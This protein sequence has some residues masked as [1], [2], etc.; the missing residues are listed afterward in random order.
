MREPSSAEPF[1]FLAVYLPKGGEPAGW[2]SGGREVGCDSS[3]L[4]AG[5]LPDLLGY[6]EQ[7]VPTFCPFHSL[8]WEGRAS[9]ANFVPL[10]VLPSGGEPTPFETRVWLGC[11]LPVWEVNLPAVFCPCGGEPACA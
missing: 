8:R 7:Y 10:C 1:P 9:E 3:M 4:D 5:D 2:S 6:G 11:V